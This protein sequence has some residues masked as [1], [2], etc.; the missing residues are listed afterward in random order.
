MIHPDMGA[1]S[2]PSLHATLLGCVLTDAAVS[3]QSL[4]TALTY[5]VDRSF[6]SISIDGDMSTN[7]T[8]VAM[9][10]GAAD[11]DMKE[12]DQD[13]DPEAYEIFRDEL[14]SFAQDLAKLVVR[15][16]EGATKFITVSVEGAATFSD[17]HAIASRISTSALVKTALYG[18]DANWGRVL[19]ATGCVQTLSKPVNPSLVTVSFVPSDGSDP[20]PVLINGEP[21]V[22]DEVRAKEILS[23]GEFE[24]KVELGI[25]SE[26][27]TYWTCDFSY[28]YV[29]IN[30][31]YRS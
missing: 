7:D 20:L 12:I 13:S 5:A 4:Q 9:A 11:L 25:G 26:K 1:P 27:A 23:R 8:I 10:N 31:D 28:E 16:G 24:V 6:N 3:P 29:R 21:E 2:P 17:A 30:G 22:V 18:E 14:T 19:A 15:D